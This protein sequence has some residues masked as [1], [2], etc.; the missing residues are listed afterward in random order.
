MH[1]LSMLNLE[2]KLMVAVD[3]RCIVVKAQVTT[4]VPGVVSGDK[5]TR[6]A[7]GNANDGA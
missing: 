7:V 6:T 1:A 3:S 2:F 4:T 5:T